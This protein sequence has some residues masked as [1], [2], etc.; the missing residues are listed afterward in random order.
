MPKSAAEVSNNEYK[1]TNYQASTNKKCLELS[2]YVLKLLMRITVHSVIRFVG[3]TGGSS[4]FVHILIGYNNLILGQFVFGLNCLCYHFNHPFSYAHTKQLNSGV[5][6]LNSRAS[7]L[8]PLKK[9]MCSNCVS[10][11]HALHVCL[12]FVVYKCIYGV[13]VC[14][15]GPGKERRG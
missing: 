1:S 12:P 15:G 6:I 5:Y 10:R 3:I 2:E 8:P 14:E 7:P 11:I 13:C 4:Q 9:M